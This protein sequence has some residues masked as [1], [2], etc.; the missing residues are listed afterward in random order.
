MA[1]SLEVVEGERRALGCN[2]VGNYHW[3][4]LQQFNQR[5]NRLHISANDAHLTVKCRRVTFL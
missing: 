2:S 5:F 4:G 1:T 3:S